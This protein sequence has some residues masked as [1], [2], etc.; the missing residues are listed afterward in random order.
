M[1]YCSWKSWYIEVGGSFTFAPYKILVLS[2]FYLEYIDQNNE[3]GPEYMADFSLERK[4]N[5]FSR[6]VHGETR[7]RLRFKPL[8][9]KISNHS[10]HERGRKTVA[11]TDRAEILL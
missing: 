1:Y 4:L 8:R 10:K 7:P 9:G 3:L 5:V 11:S 6:A 2:I